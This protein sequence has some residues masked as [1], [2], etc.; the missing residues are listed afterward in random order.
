MI[1]QSG[2]LYIDQTRTRGRGVFAAKNYEIGDLIET[3][4]V[5]ILSKSDTRK[6]EATHLYNYYFEWDADAGRSAI[7]LGYG[8]LYNHSH[9]PN[10]YY[11][12]DFEQ[13]AI[14]VVCLRAISVGEEICFNYN[15]EPD[16]NTP[17]W[18]E[19]ED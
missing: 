2:Y 10:A 3:C 4:P 17:V 7:A 13:E 8:S 15:G 18:F 5:L 14:T 12:M 16:D 11:E 9:R 19:S 1:Q 6:I